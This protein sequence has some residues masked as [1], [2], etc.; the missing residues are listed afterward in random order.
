MDSEECGEEALGHGLP[1][2]LELE[3]DLVH[4]GQKYRTSVLPEKVVMKLREGLQDRYKYSASWRLLFSTFENG[5]SYRAF[6]ESFDSSEWPFVLACKTEQGDLLG[7]FFEDR[8]RISRDTYGRPS[9]FLFTTTKHEANA[10]VVVG[11]NEL[12]IFPVSKDEGVNMYCTPDFFAFGCSGGR[13]GLLINKSLLDGETHPV[14]T[15]GNYP[16]A[17]RRRFRISYLELWLIQI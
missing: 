4:G 16:L 8:I 14:E 12:V 15:F 1:S 13:F 9:T 7:A 2:L 11:S 17:S 10:P 3:F 6:L 5:F